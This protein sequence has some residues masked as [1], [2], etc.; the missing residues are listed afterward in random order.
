LN[1]TATRGALGAGLKTY[2]GRQA[3]GPLRYLLEQLLFALAGWVPTVIGIGL[4]AVLYRL[5]MRLDGVAVIESGVRLRFASLIH[6]GRNVF[7]DQSV[8]LHACPQGIA[9]GD[10]SLVMHGSVLHVYNFRNLPH[11]FIHIGHD[12]LIGELNVLRGQ[13]GIRLGDRVY[14][15]PLV[16]ILAVNHV[17]ADPARPFVEQGI[18]AQ[19][20]A[21]QRRGW[22][23]SPC[24]PRHP[25]GRCWR[26]VAQRAVVG[27][28]GGTGQTCL[29]LTHTEGPGAPFHAKAGRSEPA[30]GSGA[31]FTVAWPVGCAPPCMAL[32]LL[33]PCQR[34][35]SPGVAFRCLPSPTANSL[36]RMNSHG[37]TAR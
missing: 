2:I 3:A 34:Q 27:R 32:S 28:T 16:Q 21:S 1:R 33:R 13:G 8:Y 36:L 35:N 31:G 17:Y 4:R 14:T 12:S 19:G 24:A 23:S 29:F 26:A 6:L 9:I 10:N 7:L 22:H 20:A 18:T 11:A 15:S 5:I 37:S 25:S 30:Q